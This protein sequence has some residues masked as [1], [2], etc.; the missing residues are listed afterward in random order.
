MNDNNKQM[1]LGLANLDQFDDIKQLIEISV[2][3]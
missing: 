3:T 1:N 2:I